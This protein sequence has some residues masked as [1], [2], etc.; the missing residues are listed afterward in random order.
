MY[1]TRESMI[2]NFESQAFVYNKTDRIV[3]M[4]MWKNSIFSYLLTSS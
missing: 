1:D 3:T 4:D 2:F